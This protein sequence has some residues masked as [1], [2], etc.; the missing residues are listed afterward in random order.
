MD[1]DT[2]QPDEVLDAI[3]RAEAALAAEAE[4][5]TERLRLQC[6]EEERR[7]REEEER[8][9]AELDSAKTREREKTGADNAA[10]QA[11]YTRFLPGQLDTNHFIAWK[12]AIPKTKDTTPTAAAA[13]SAAAASAAATATPNQ[14]RTRTANGVPA[15][16]GR[17]LN[18]A[19]LTAYSSYDDMRLWLDPLSAASRRRWLTTLT[20][21]TPS[22]CHSVQLPHVV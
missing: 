20:K 11:P 1:P 12:A 18:D 21:T 6:E 19:T 16:L 5:E 15:P 17:S 13:A 10:A 4:A 7:R 2:Q 3:E 8:R 22:H 9:L 14:P